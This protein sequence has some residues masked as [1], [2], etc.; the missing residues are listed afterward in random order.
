[1]LPATW[2]IRR[3]PRS[4]RCCT[5]DLTPPALSHPKRGPGAVS[6]LH[7]RHSVQDEF[8]YVLAGEPTLFTDAGETQL[9]PGMVA[10]FAAG[11]PAHHLE[12]RTAR[13][14]LILEVGDRLPDDTVGY[15]SDDIQAVMG[16]DGKWM[17]THKDGMPY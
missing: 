5:A 14:C 16:S 10:G 17:F 7:H 12:N 3:C 2:A 1:M 13:D 6:A 4:K 11:G 9:H 8:I 15:P